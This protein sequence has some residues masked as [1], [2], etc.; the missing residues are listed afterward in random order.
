MPEDVKMLIKSQRLKIEEWC[1]QVPILGFISGRYDLNLIREH[2]AECLF[3][4][5]GKVRVAKNSNKIMFILTKTFV[6][7]ISLIT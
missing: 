4:T 2:F 7:L 3:D 1:N 6:F 5:T